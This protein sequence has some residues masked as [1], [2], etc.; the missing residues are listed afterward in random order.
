MGAGNGGW[1]GRNAFTLVE[2]LVSLAIVAI[3]ATLIT[4]GTTSMLSNAESAQCLSNLRQISTLALTYAGEHNG[5]F[6]HGAYAAGYLGGGVNWAPEHFLL[7]YDGFRKGSDGR[8]I[9][10]RNREKTA[11]SAARRSI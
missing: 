3:L 9:E 11:F 6:P 4:R 2:L 1:T 10:G 8:I 7:D 5:Y